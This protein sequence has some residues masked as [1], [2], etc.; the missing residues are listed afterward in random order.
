MN[1]VGKEQLPVIWLH[2]WGMSAA[3]W[4][5]LP[6]FAAHDSYALDLPGHGA[7]PWDAALGSDVTRWA[8]ALLERAP[9][10]ALWVG[11]SLGGLLAL[12][13]ARIAPERMAGLY[14]I[15]SSPCFVA[16]DGWSCAMREETFAQFEEGLA[17]NHALTL[18]RFLAL[19]THGADDALR[20]R[21]VLN[22]AALDAE[23]ADVGALR[24]GLGLLRQ[25]DLRQVVPSLRLPFA[26]MLGGL[27]RIVPPCMADVYKAWQPGA[28]VLMRARAGHAPF[29][30]M[31][32]DVAKDG[33][34][35]ESWLL[36]MQEKAR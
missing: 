27:D 15:A 6:A 29:L 3:I 32:N 5:A 13:M 26:V 21:G 24:A 20:V 35:V 22:A 17:Q 25:A 1:H 12:E 30:D 10:R 16:K 4:Q 34:D 18:R 14:L 31:S 33:L 7:T 23:R 36:A 11:W 19:Q 9:P 8:E 28:A 2:G